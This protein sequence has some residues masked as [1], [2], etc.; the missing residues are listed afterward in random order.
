MKSG[1]AVVIALRSLRSARLRT[2]L[3][4]LGIAVGV[5][6]VIT[7]VGLGDGIKTGLNDSLGGFGTSIFVNPG[8]ATVPG[9][10]GR[11]DQVG[12]IGV[13]AVSVGQ[14]DAALLDIYRVMD[15]RHRISDPGLRDY[16]IT[17]TQNQVNKTN[18]FLDSVTKF[19][20]AIAGIA[21]FV[22]G[23]GISNIMLVTVTERTHEIGIRKAVGARRSAILK[24]FLIE[25]IVLSSFGGLAGVLLGIG[26]VLAGARLLPLISSNYGAPAISPLAVVSAFSISLLLGML[27]GSYPALRAARMRPVEALGY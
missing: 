23:L 7:L 24:Q 14:V 1:E 4:S 6:A 26:L 17:A 15:A 2:A 5:A 19:T 25:S 20:L 18:D 10:R 27:S 3:T 22:G 16:T 13:K 8:G 21:L 9:A 11:T 12:Q